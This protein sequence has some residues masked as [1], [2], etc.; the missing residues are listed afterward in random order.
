MKKALLLLF[1]PISG[2]VFSQINADDEPVQSLNNNGLHGTGIY[3]NDESKVVNITGNTVTACDSGSTTLSVTGACSFDW[4]SDSN[5]TSLMVSNSDLTTPVIYNDQTYYLASVE[6]AGV[7]T[8]T[9]MPAQSGTFSGSVRGYYFQAPVDFLITGLTI[10]T[11]ASTGLITAAIVRFN[12]GPPP[13]YGTVTNDFTQ[14]GY[15][16]SSADDTINVC[17]PI[18]AGDYIGVLGYR[19]T[20]NSYAT[21][22]STT[23]IL[24]NSVTIERCGMQFNLTTTAPQDLWTET[25]GSISRVE[26]LYASD[27]DTIVTEVNVTVPQSSSE[28]I[29]ESICLGDSIF[30]GGDYQYSAG[31]YTDSMVSVFGCDS[32]ITTNLLVNSL[33]NAVVQSPGTLTATQTGVTYQWMDCSSGLPLL[34]ETGQSL[35]PSVNGSYAVILDDGNCPD[36]SICY[37]VDDLGIVPINS[38]DLTIYPNPANDFVIIT[39]SKSF[40][41]VTIEVLDIAAKVVKSLNKVSGTEI[42]L[43]LEGISTGT[44]TLRVTGNNAVS[45]TTIIK[46]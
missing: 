23:N 35:V 34:G 3:Y 18:Q 36:T 45:Y 24:G 28:I 41:D 15:W 10:P 22:P 25:G 27:A 31:M 37:L 26:L 43:D 1:I 19:G 17:I 5:L 12:S 16:P 4:Y 21:G 32:I 44:Y 29:T 9:P 20:V 8:I 6:P 13:V 30:V 42:K 38:N 46:K 2:M 40:E 14:L 39:G 7:P 11:T 33:N